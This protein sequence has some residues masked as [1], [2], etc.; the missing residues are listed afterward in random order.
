VFLP[1]V[2]IEAAMSD[3]PGSP[4]DQFQGHLT[5]DVLLIMSTFSDELAARVIE[6]SPELEPRVQSVLSDP[7]KYI[8]SLL[9][10]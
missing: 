3:F 2:T 10:G 8:Q 7:E 5:D 4:D 6:Y 1:E 9:D